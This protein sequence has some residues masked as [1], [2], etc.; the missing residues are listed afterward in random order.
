MN[1]AN[2]TGKYLQD[3]IK[4]SAQHLQLG[5]VRF[6]DAGFVGDKSEQR[7]FTSKNVADF[8]VYGPDTGIAF[9]EAKNRDSS[10]TFESITQTADLLKLHN[11]HQALGITQALCGVL[12]MFRNKNKVFWVPVENLTT[13]QKKTNKKSFNA[14]DVITYHCGVELPLFIP[15]KKRKALIDLTAIQ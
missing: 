13:L 6:K 3:L 11:T 15:P 9:I 14:T 10:L 12:V 1:E 5:C 2:R 8:I 4:L 7:R